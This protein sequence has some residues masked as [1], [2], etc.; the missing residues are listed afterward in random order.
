MI[1]F[2]HETFEEMGDEAPLRSV[3]EFI[4][5]MD[6]RAGVLERGY[7]GEVFITLL[8]ADGLEDPATLVVNAALREESRGR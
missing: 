2:K 4:D 6:H 3:V 8:G 5:N 7:D 1:G